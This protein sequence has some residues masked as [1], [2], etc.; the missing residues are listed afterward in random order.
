MQ[1]VTRKALRTKLAAQ[2]GGELS[3]AETNLCDNFIGGLVHLRSRVGVGHGEPGHPTEFLAALRISND[4]SGRSRRCLTA[5]RQPCPICR[6]HAD[7]RV[8]KSQSDQMHFKLAL[9]DGYQMPCTAML[10]RIDPVNPHS[11]TSLLIS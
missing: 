9:P 4:K 11:D 6:H 2:N 10:L 1:Q 5:V 3:L 7:R 8:L